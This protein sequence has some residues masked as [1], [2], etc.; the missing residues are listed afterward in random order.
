MNGD[1]LVDDTLKRDSPLKCL[2]HRDSVNNCIH[3]TLNVIKP[4]MEAIS[5][6][7]VCDLKQPL[8]KVKIRISAEAQ[9]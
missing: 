5:L 7:P 4:V 2:T 3:H 1:H 9:Q 6:R 8:R